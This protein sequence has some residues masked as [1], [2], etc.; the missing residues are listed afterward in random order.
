MDDQLE[1]GKGQVTWSPRDSI[2]IKDISFTCLKQE[3]PYV[4]DSIC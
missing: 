1:K 4:L 3:S 2:P